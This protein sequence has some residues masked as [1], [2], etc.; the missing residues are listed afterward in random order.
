MIIIDGYNLLFAQKGEIFDLETSRNGLITL[1]EKYNSKKGGTIKI[2]F[3]VKTDLPIYDKKIKAMKGKIEVIFSRKG[4]SADDYIIELV[5]DTD[6]RKAIRVVSSDKKVIGTI[7]KLEAQSISS[8]DFFNEI[9]EFIKA[10]TSDDY[11]YEKEHGISKSE[12]DYWLKVFGLDK[13]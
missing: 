3:D 4:I 1:L 12:V 6:N 7:K 5:K 13:K 11:Y 2:V 9:S 10:D 8:E